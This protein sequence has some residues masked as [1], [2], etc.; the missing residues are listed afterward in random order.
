MTLA[1]FPELKNLA[2]LEKLKLADQLWQAG[3][4]DASR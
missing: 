3:V 4:S 2:N 1:S